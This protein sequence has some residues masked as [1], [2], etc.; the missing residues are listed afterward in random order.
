MDSKYRIGIYSIYI[1]GATR[2]NFFAVVWGGGIKNL[3]KIYFRLVYGG[4]KGLWLSW[5]YD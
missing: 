1:S 5:V 3:K 2:I 4:E